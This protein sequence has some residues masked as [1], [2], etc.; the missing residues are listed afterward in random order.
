MNT[1]AA[2][3]PVAFTRADGRLLRADA[4]G[5]SDGQPVIFLHGGGQTRVAWRG[6]LAEMSARGYRAYT[7]DQRGHGE[8]DRAATYTQDDY[9]R[10]V[11]ELVRQSGGRPVLVG[12][13]LGGLSSMIFAGENPHAAKALILV[14][15][16]PAVDESGASRI[17]GFMDA[18][19]DGFSS[20]EEAAEI[21]S[22]YLPH[23]RKPRNLDGLRKNLVE[24][25]DGRWRWHWDFKFING[26][27]SGYRR[28]EP[29][30]RAALARMVIPT[31]LVRGA[32]SELVTEEAVADFLQI[33]PNAQVVDIKEAG[34]MVSGDSNEAFMD[35]VIRFIQTNYDIQ[36]N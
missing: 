1:A 4:A 31:L 27:E 18:Y 8:S 12:A 34:H 9:V 13:S 17:R 35:A 21:I 7:V 23:R 22:E 32:Q 11:A 16:T 6:A 15:V 28:D 33:R 26:G 36:L 5:P 29:R 14:D 10:D 25:P 20:L 24:G 3:E 2:I 30:T 19:P